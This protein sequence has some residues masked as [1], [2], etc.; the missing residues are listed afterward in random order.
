MKEPISGIPW[1]RSR[2]YER[3]LLVFDDS[4]TFPRSYADWFNVAEAKIRY[5]EGQGKRII[6]VPIDPDYFPR[7]CQTNGYK[8]DAVGRRAFVA[9]LLAGPEDQLPRL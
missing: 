8:T 7:W 6:K 2:D 1:C 3:L 5:F 4:L 9:M